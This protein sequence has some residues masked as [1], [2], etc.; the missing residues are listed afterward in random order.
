MFYQE[1]LLADALRTAGELD[2][3]CRLE[4]LDPLYV[5]SILEKER[6]QKLAAYL[7]AIV[8]KRA[9]GDGGCVAREPVKD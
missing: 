9:H 4:G 7:G 3:C 1:Y 2:T 6:A 5:R 8:K